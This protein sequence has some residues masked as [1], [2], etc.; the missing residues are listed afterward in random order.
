MGGLTR[1]PS[2]LSVAFHK[3]GLLERLGMVAPQLCRVMPPKKGHG[4][5]DVGLG[6]NSGVGI[7]LFL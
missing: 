2:S 5:Q 3:L 4:V 1:G 7:W 6:G